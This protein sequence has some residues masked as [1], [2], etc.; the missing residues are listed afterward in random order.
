MTELNGRRPARAG[1]W[2][3][4][5][6]VAM[7]AIVVAANAPKGETSSPERAPAP[8]PAP[9]NQEAPKPTSDAITYDRQKAILLARAESASDAASMCV[10]DLIR[11]RL[12]RGVRSRDAIA[13]EAG[14]MCSAPLINTGMPKDDAIAGMKVEAYRRMDA[15]ISEGQ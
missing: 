5:G 6:F 10:V 13:D 8:R 9:V 12:A 14:S 7:V 2:V 15:I 3:V 1:G 11:A 4:F